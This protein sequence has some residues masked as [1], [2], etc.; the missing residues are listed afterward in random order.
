MSSDEYVPD[1]DEEAEEE[2]EDEEEEHKG[3]H[4]AGQAGEEDDDDEEELSQGYT[5]Y[6]AYTDDESGYTTAGVT[7]GELVSD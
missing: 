5:S 7:T 6:G 3:A 2:E 4:R 1:T